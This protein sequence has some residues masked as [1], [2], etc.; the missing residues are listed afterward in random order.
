M[1][2]TDGWTLSHADFKA[3]V[4]KTT[5]A[6]MGDDAAVYIFHAHNY[7]DDSNASELEALEKWY[8]LQVP[9]VY[10]AQPC[11]I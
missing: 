5:K 6:G 1:A 8:A 4:A 2:C 10:H 7:A 9:C 11:R 3:H